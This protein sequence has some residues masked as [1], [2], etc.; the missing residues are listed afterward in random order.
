MALPNWQNNKSYKQYDIIEEPDGS[1]IFYYA[2]VNHTSLLS[3]SGSSGSS[4]TAG[5]F[6]NDKVKWAGIIDL[7]GKKHPHFFWKSDYDT[8]YTIKAETKIT[9][10]GDG[11]EQRSKV[12]MDNMLLNLD[13]TFSDRNYKE[14]VAILHF[15]NMRRGYVPFVFIPE[16]IYTTFKSQS[17]KFFICKKWKHTPIFDENN[18]ISCT[19]EQVPSVN[20]YEVIR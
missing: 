20:D 4:G 6:F 9:T 15:L 7:N 14:A 18:R 8:R 10:F 13:L 11:Y 12:S 3:T 5:T 1:N 16:N 19:F 17:N 2:I